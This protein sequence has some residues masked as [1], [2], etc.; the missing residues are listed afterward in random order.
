[1]DRVTLP[2][3]PDWRAEA[4][5]L[6]FTFADMHGAP[7]WDESSAYRFTLAE[8]EDQIEGQVGRGQSQCAEHAEQ[9]EFALVAMA[10]DNM[11]DIRRL[12]GVEACERVVES[13]GRLLRANTRAMDS[14]CRLGGDRFVVLTDVMQ[15]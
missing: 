5:R 7:Y 2:E 1:M 6:G 9:R 15:Q 14:P 4:E 8:V 12:H 3:R 10:I 11:D 13:L